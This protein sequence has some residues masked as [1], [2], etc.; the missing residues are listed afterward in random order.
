MV[1]L[2]ERDMP[3][4]CQ[5]LWDIESLQSSVMGV[6]FAPMLC[7]L[8]LSAL[9]LRSCRCGL[10]LYIF[11]SLQYISL[12][13]RER[14]VNQEGSISFGLHEAL[15]HNLI[16]GSFPVW[17]IL[18]FLTCCQGPEVNPLS[19]CQ[20]NATHTQKTRL[21]SDKS[22][23][24]HT[25]RTGLEAIWQA[26]QQILAFFGL[27]EKALLELVLQVFAADSETPHLWSCR[28]LTFRQSNWMRGETRPWRT[29]RP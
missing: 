28:K 16:L 7:V 22:I 8:F 17:L 20:G 3:C 14:K 2:L 13:A 27:L 18:N 12:Y 6:C 11:T 24:T 5:S 15:A 10:Y 9:D 1:V 21:T 25:D 26:L 23:Q 29:C 4:A 19:C